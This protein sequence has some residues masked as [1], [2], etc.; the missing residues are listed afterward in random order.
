MCLP[1]IM[2]ST[3]RC[4]R[5]DSILGEGNHFFY[6]GGKDEKRLLPLVP[7]RSQVSKV[8]VKT[9]FNGCLFFLFSFFL[10]PHF[11]NAVLAT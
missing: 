7:R 11:N 3:P 10:L 2:A 6:L 5:G 9:L 4:G 1:S 8:Y